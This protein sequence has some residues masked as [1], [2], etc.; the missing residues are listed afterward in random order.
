MNITALYRQHLQEGKELAYGKWVASGYRD[1][2]EWK[3]F[4]YF[5][6]QLTR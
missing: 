6:Q 1:I 5:W 3:R 2:K 4:I